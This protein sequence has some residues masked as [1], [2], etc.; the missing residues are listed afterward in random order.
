MTKLTLVS[1]TSGTYSGAPITTYHL[2][3]QRDRTNMAPPPVIVAAQC[4]NQEHARRLTACWNACDGTSTDWLEANQ[5]IVLLG[6]PVSERVKAIQQ[7]RDKLL[8]AM[9]QLD[10]AYAESESL[11]ASGLTDKEIARRWRE[12][13]AAI[14]EAT[15]ITGEGA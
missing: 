9:Q 10:E 13:R 5:L 6:E 15:T 3:A 1:T 11:P 2:I 12:V 14:A 8:A 4:D 7:Q